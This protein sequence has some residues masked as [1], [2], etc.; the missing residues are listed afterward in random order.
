MTNDE[1]LTGT[2]T[3]TVYDES[4]KPI[5]NARIQI[6]KGNVKLSD[7][8]TSYSGESII[9]DLTFD[10]YS[11]VVSRTGY[12]T[13]TSTL[14][15]DDETVTDEITLT[16]NP[17][18]EDIVEV[19]LDERYTFTVTERTIQDYTMSTSISTW[20]KT[21]LEA[22]TDDNDNVIL[23]KVNNGF[24]QDSLK[25]FGNKPVCDVYIDKVNYE[26]NF[27]YHI[28]KSVDTIVL[29]YLKGANNHT[30]NKA[31]EL[32]DY[33]M[34]EFIE[35][36]DWRRLDNIV[37]DTIITNS[38]LRVQPLNKKWGVVGAFQLTHILY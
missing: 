31:C 12:S 7:T 18:P 29:F 5:K 28:P 13:S 24:N 25:T 36:M 10:T 1:V 33:I 26:G 27:D 20:L 8:L 22:L 16:Q 19:D 34:Q 11:L 21:N 35:N 23:G 37:K 9:E 2:V 4:D 30:Y 3:L 14:T 17:I 32:H 38:E 15:V 6:F